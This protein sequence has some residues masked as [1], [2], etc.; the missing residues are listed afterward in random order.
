M[1]VAKALS[2][3]LNHPGDILDYDEAIGGDLKLNLKILIPV[4]RY[5]LPLEQAA[6]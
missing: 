3:A 5:Q 1:D 2:V 4:G 6:K